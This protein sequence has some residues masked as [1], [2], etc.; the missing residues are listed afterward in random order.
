MP[1]AALNKVLSDAV[2]RHP[3]P[4]VK[5]K[6]PRFFYATQA[7]IEPPTFVLFASGAEAVHFAYSRFLENRLR[8]TFDFGGAPLRLVFRERARVDLEPRRRGGGRRKGTSKG[9]ARGSSRS[10]ARSA[11]SGTRRSRA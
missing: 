4:A 7:A 1:T 11:A 3:A 9:A 6:R 8:D 2:S 5:G 10:G